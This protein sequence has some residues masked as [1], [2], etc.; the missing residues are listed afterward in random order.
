MLISPQQVTDT[1]YQTIQELLKQ[2]GLEETEPMRQTVLLDD[3][4]FLGYRFTGKS[5][6]VEWLAQEN[7]ILAESHDGK[8]IFQHKI[9]QQN[10][11]KDH[12]AENMDSNLTAA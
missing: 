11:N 2:H 3:S 7:L 12:H 9:Q 4:A 10:L 1:I 6:L 8:T 5:V